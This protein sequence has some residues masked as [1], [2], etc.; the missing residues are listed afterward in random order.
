[1]ALHGCDNPACCNVYSS[2]H[3]HE[4]D[5]ALNTQEK[6]LRN[7]QPPHT[8]GGEH[9]AGAKLTNEEAIFIKRRYAQCGVSFTCL[10]AEFNVSR[11]TIS[12]IIN[13]ERYVDVR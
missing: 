3:V 7:R 4:G 8:R 12:R 10:A 5:N 6:F 2:L 9:N 1:M 13:G 11:K